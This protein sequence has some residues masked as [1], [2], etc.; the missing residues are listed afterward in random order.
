[1]EFLILLLTFIVN[2]IVDAAFWGLI[3]SLGESFF[4]GAPLGEDEFLQK[5]ISYSL[6]CIIVPA[7]FSGMDFMQQRF[8]WA[9]GGRKAKGEEEAY[10]RNILDDIC[11]KAGLDSSAYS[12]YV[13]DAEMFNAWAIGGGHITVTRALLHNFPPEEVK[14]ILAHE[15]GHL[16][17]GDTRWGLLR[18]GIGWFGNVIVAVYNLFIIFTAFIRFIPIIGLIWSVFAF[19]I[20]IQY[21]ALRFFLELPLWL[22]SQF[23][24]RQNEYEADQFACDIGFGRELLSGLIRLDYFYRS[25]KQNPLAALFSDHP[26]TAKRITRIE[27]CLAGNK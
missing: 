16:E 10:L 27:A 21:Y 19:M 26:D 18:Y 15:V 13:S 23:G 12:L 6:F 2:F 5:V 17:N 7:V 22:I 4:Y 24:S 1:M 11:E 20:T 25:E 14:G 9:G 8:V 3:L